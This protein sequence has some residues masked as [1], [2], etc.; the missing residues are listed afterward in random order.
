MSSILLRREVAAHKT[1]NQTDSCWKIACTGARQRVAVATE[2]CS[3]RH[4]TNQDVELPVGAAEA[5]GQTETSAAKTAGGERD[6]SL[7]AAEIEAADLPE[8][9]FFRHIFFLWLPS[10]CD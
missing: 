2:C 6:W 5:D 7:L 4:A 9:K 1:N 8:L 3:S 10:D